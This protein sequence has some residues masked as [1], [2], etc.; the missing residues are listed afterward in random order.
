MPKVSHGHRSLESLCRARSP[1]SYDHW[2]GVL[3]PLGA[4]PRERLGY[5]TQSF[6]T[7]E[8]NSSFYRWPR[9]ATFRAWNR[10]LP[11][12]FRFSVKAPRG[13]THAKK[14]YAPEAWIE[15]IAASWHELDDKRAVLLVQLGPDL[16]RDDAR[17]AYFL[18]LLPRGIQTSVEF[19]FAIR[20]GSMNMCSRCSSATRSRIALR[21]ARTSRVCF[22][23][24]RRS[25]TSACTAP[26][27]STCTRVPTQSRTCVGGLTGCTNGM[28][29]ARTSSCTSTTTDTVTRCVTPAHSVNC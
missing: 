16:A 1:W 17:L 18:E 4:P 24:P 21:V 13:L 20:A 15:R 28:L 9:V 6:Q 8:L 26:T 19:G 23:Q 10:R 14:L 3:Y 27:S 12:A 11:A 5:Y 25:C 2:S 22:E 29:P 7:V